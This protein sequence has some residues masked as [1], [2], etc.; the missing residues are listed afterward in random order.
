MVAFFKFSNLQKKSNTFENLT[1]Y[2]EHKEQRENFHIIV[3]I[4]NGNFRKF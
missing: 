2:E 3:R 1:H 4:L